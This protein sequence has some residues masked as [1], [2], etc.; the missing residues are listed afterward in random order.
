MIYRTNRLIE[1]QL[2]DIDKQLL[3]A[4]TE[5]NWNIFLLLNALIYM[6]TFYIGAPQSLDPQLI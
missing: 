5:M 4:E 2:A 6:Y 3:K 1:E